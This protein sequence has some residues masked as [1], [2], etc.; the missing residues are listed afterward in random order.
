VG[1]TK[2]SAWAQPERQAASKVVDCEH[3]SRLLKKAQISSASH[4][5]MKVF[6]AAADVLLSR[7]ATAGV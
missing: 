4:F 7:S 5:S 6:G 3:E 1:I 2:I